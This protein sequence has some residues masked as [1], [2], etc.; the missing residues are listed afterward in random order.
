MDTVPCMQIFTGMS[1][2][3]MYFFGVLH[4]S[5]RVFQSKGVPCGGPYFARR[6]YDTIGGTIGG[7]ART[8]AVGRYG[9]PVRTE[10]E[11]IDA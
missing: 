3:L 11:Y 5:V 9:D 8:A 2:F 1:I 10:M 6:K 7:S 4:G